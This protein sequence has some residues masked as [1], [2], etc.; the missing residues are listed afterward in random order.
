MK[1][2]SAIKVYY[3]MLAV[4]LWWF[5]HYLREPIVIVVAVL[6]LPLLLTCLISSTLEVIKPVWLHARIL[7]R[8]LLKRK[9]PIHL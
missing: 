3:L 5:W 6:A 2:K 9:K 1:R 4:E 7:Q 8:K